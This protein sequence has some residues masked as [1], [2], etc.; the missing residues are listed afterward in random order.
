MHTDPGEWTGPSIVETYSRMLPEDRAQTESSLADIKMAL[1]I[2][3][4]EAVELL[5]FHVRTNPGGQT[6]TYRGHRVSDVGLKALTAHAGK[7]DVVRTEQF[8]SVSDKRSVAKSFASGA[9]DA[10]PGTFNEVMLTVMG[11]SAVKLFSPVNEAE[12][13]YPLE[14]AFTIEH[15]GVSNLAIRAYAPAATHFVLRETSVSAQRRKTLP[16]MTDPGARRG[17]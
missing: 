17:R 13:I 7:G 12:R 5:D 8:M 10:R 14:T 9:Y 6:T 11:S 16:F 1:S 15:A 4:T 3:R 2:S